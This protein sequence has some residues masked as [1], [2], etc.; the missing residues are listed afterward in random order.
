MELVCGEHDTNIG[1]HTLRSLQTGKK[2]ITIMQEC[3]SLTHIHHALFGHVHQSPHELCFLTQ[4][5]MLTQEQHMAKY[6]EVHHLD[7][8]AH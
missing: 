2:W 7:Q 5:L 6:D 4:D 3:E 8:E 1:I